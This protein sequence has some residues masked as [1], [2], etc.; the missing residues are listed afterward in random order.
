MSFYGDLLKF[1]DR[2]ALETSQQSMTY[3]QLF[4]ESDKIAEH[5]NKRCLVF[6]I[7]NNNVESV[8]GYVGFLRNRI[9][10]I[11]INSAINMQL[12]MELYNTYCPQYIWCPNG[13]IP[14]K[15]VYAYKEYEL[16]RTECT[17]APKMAEDLA[18][19]LTTSGS[20][21]SPKLVRQT[22]KNIDANTASIV[23]YLNIKPD[24]RA[25][26]TL[27]MSYTYGLSIIQSHLL[28]GARIILTGATLMQK[29]FWRLFK[30]KGAT[31]FGG[32]PY[33]YEALKR[34]RFLNMNLPSLRYI[35]QAGGKLDK[36]L[37]FEYADG[38][39]K[40]GKQFIVMYGATEA[41]A[42]MSYVPANMSVEK[43]GSIGIAIPGGRFELVDIDSNIITEPDKVGELVYYGDN[44]T[45]GYAESRNDLCKPDEWHGRLE[46]GD[47][48]KRDADGYYYV[49]GR[50]KRFLKLYGNRVSLM[51]VE[52]LLLQ[53]GYN[54]VCVGEDDHMRIYTTFTDTGAVLDYISRIMAI[55]SAAF[56][57]IH[58]DDIPRNSSGKVLYSELK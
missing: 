27:P 50:K 21:G 9:V 30:E 10:P 13:F 33:T 40:Q 24:D 51:E 34:L 18:L 23:E 43:A 31:T 55:N 35:T 48:A 17:D 15:S 46:T 6:C 53:Q 37:H 11:M 25:I 16:I 32:V 56:E 22:Y 54:A 58:I 8:A 28:A 5:I 42:R 26:T 1:S 36:Q 7:C 47:M 52:D 29:E 2:I 19:L 20:T 41:T 14:G 12:F 4:Q 49:V 38:L 44:V 45:P 57:V 3:V 39:R